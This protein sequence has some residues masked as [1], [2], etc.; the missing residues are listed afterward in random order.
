MR[1]PGISLIIVAAVG[2]ASATWASSAASADTIL[3]SWTRRDWTLPPAQDTATLKGGTLIVREVSADGIWEENGVALSDIACGYR[4]TWSRLPDQPNPT[5][6][7]VKFMTSI[8]EYRHP[9][10]PSHRGPG[11]VWVSDT[12][13]PTPSY[14]MSYL[15]VVFDWSD[16]ATAEAFMYKV[17]D[18]LGERGQYCQ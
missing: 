8:D 11:R 6:V 1:Q 12:P 4:Y 18:A 5:T 16:E 15:D 14:G 10:D 7:H 13:S 3:A 17:S 2:L 9:G